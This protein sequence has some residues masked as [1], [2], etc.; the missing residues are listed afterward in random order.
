MADD[1]AGGAPLG[2]SDI[3]RLCGDILDSKV[4]AIMATG[5]SLGDLEAAVGWLAGEDDVTGDRH[6]ELSGSAGMIYDLL[7]SD[8]DFPDEDRA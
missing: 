5:A 6:R 8:A 4:A 7:A 2:A 3:R 1:Q